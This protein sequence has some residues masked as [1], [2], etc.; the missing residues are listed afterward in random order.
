MVSV[1]EIWSGHFH[2]SLT[3]IYNIIVLDLLLTIHL[4]VD[5]LNNY[6]CLFIYGDP[7]EL[8]AVLLLPPW[9]FIGNYKHSNEGYVC[10]YVFK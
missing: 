1:F 9:S 10:T 8:L 3:L 5:N 6:R 2:F 4:M 7:V